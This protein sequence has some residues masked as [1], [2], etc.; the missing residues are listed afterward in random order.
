MIDPLDHTIIWL[1]GE[2]TFPTLSLIRHREM[3]WLSGS[4]GRNLEY[5]LVSLFFFPLRC[6]SR[7]WKEGR[8][9]VAKVPL[10]HRANIADQHDCSSI[11]PRSFP[12]CLSI[13]YSWPV[14]RSLLSLL[15]KLGH[16]F[17]DL[18]RCMH[19]REIPRDFAFLSAER[20]INRATMRDTSGSPA[21]CESIRLLAGTR[22][23]F[24]RVVRKVADGRFVEITEIFKFS[25][26]CIDCG[27]NLYR[28]M[29]KGGQMWAGSFPLI[30]YILFS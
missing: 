24:V 8:E 6:G 2:T 15:R 23:Y 22:M 20:K 17:H 3:G 29:K 9:C 14:S 11:S 10:R 25:G 28:G 1:S 5:G 21:V 12:S 18:V 16:A 19:V 26:H 7:K 4:V 30:E 27:V 13:G